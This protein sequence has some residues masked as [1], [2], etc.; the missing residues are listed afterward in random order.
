MHL[1]IDSIDYKRGFLGPGYLPL[2]YWPSDG[3]HFHLVGFL[4]SWCHLPGEETARDPFI[5]GMRGVFIVKSGSG[6]V[7]SSSGW[8]KCLERDRRW[9]SLPLVGFTCYYWC[10]HPSFGWLTFRVLVFP[11]L[12][13]KSEFA[14]TALSECSSAQVILTWSL[15]YTALSKGWHRTSRFIFFFRWMLTRV[16]SRL[17]Y[18]RAPLSRSY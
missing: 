14:V 16:C 5:Q 4:G 8:F 9:W 15:Q 10:E 7:D 13:A 6:D 3:D 17:P 1:F 11:K 2:V 18:L 12:N